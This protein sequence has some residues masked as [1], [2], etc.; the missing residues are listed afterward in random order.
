MSNIQKATIVFEEHGPEQVGTRSIPSPGPKQV[1]VKLTAAAVNP[2]DW[3]ARE[4]SHI[5]QEYP[6]VLGTD[7][8]G[9]VEA[10]GPGVT[11]LKMGDRVFF[12]GRYIAD[13]ATFQQ[14]ALADS[15]LLA[16]IPEN[17]T[18]DQASTIPVAI[19]AAGFSLFQKS[20]IPFPLD[21]PSASGRP[22]LIFGGSSSVGQYAIQ[23]ARIAGFSPIVTTA[24][25]KHTEYLKNIGATHVIERNTDAK[26]IQAAFKEPVSLIVDTISL[27]ET[28][29]LAFE[30]LH[31]PKPV[32]DGHLSIV[33]RLLEDLKAKNAALG[34]KAV[35][36]N[37]V[38][39]IGHL[40][41]DIAVPFWR[42]IER[43]IKDGSLVPNRVQVV[44]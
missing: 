9:V 27:P 30:V 41:P 26:I 5:A 29:S 18:D 2:I 16:K 42:G 36:V 44:A 17:V 10:L 19:I 7:G 37:E 28:Q 22:V 25:A 34:S 20:G 15:Q 35:S 43:W 6:L 38:L 21:G 1:L 8:A 39:G 32:S 40:N 33:L 13:L 31:T 11:E 12:Q 3:K 4:Y 14:Y 23:L 24:S